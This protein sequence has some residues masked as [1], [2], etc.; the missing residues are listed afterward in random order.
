MVS[1]IWLKP[2]ATTLQI[3]DTKT[4]HIGVDIGASKTLVAATASHIEHSKTTTFKTSP[5][6]SQFHADLSR[7]VADVNDTDTQVEAITVAA[8]GVIDNGVIKRGGQITWQDINLEDE[9]QQFAPQAKVTV[10]NDAAAG[11]M[12]ESVAGAGENYNVVL[13]VTISTGI[14]SA[15]V[16]D[17]RLQHQF[18]N[19]E[20]GQMILDH[21]RLDRFETLA[22]GSAFNDTYHHLG[23]EENDPAHWSEYGQLVGTGLFNMITITRPDVVVIG[24]SMGVHFDKYEHATTSQIDKL[25]DG[26]YN[27][28]VITAAHEPESAVAYGCLLIAQG[29]VK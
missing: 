21:Q 12:Y 8:P 25:I 26:L 2:L 14:G 13:Y 3:S 20:G 29:A 17:N 16:I 4:M 7:A 1:F 22:S 11:G 18:G 5:D 28:P 24:G 10:L 23:S 27:A 9:L 6:F 19:S 15:L